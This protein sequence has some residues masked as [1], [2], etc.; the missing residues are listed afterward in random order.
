MRIFTFYYLLIIIKHTNELKETKIRRAH[1][2]SRRVRGSGARNHE[3][4]PRYI[5][6]A[7]E[8]HAAGGWRT[9]CTDGLSGG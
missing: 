8:K 9:G 3:G 7:S 4:L 2:E 6:A 1:Q 5:R